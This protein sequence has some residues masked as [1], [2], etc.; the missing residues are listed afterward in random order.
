MIREPL[1]LSIKAVKAYLRVTWTYTLLFSFGT[2]DQ[3]DNQLR[4]VDCAMAALNEK[5]STPMSSQY[6]PFLLCEP[7]LLDRRLDSQTVF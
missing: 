4:N 7:G 6:S 5:R 3:V 2:E 1:T